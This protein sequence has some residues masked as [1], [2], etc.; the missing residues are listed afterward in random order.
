MDVIS[1]NSKYS[2]TLFPVQEHNYCLQESP[3]TLKRRNENLAEMLDDALVAKRLCTERLREAE[4]RAT[5]AE[6]RANA[7]EAKASEA[8]ARALADWANLCMGCVACV[9]N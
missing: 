1:R 6:A 2:N 9:L 8:E 5:A 4:T 7:A 3:R